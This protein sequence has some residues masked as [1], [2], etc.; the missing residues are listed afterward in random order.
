MKLKCRFQVLVTIFLSAL[1][2]GLPAREAMAAS[3]AKPKFKAVAIDFLT[4][5][6]FKSANA[7]CEKLVVKSGKELCGTW[8]IKQFEYGY[9]RAM[10]KHPVDFNKMTNDAL[11][12][13]AESAH[14]KLTPEVRKKLIDLYSEMTPF[15]DTVAAVKKL[16]AAGLHLATFSFYSPAVQRASAQRAGVADLF[17]DFL[18]TERMAEV[19]PAPSAYDVIASKLHLEKGSIVYVTS[20]YWDVFGAKNSGYPTYLVKRVQ[21]PEDKYGVHPDKTVADLTALVP[22]LTK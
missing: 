11:D 3:P 7:A 22:L 1:M 20:A 13:A 6:D 10:G 19:R 2:L 5:F 12:F 8:R 4:L 17:D 9:L 15:P 14:V 21:S 16:K 18:S